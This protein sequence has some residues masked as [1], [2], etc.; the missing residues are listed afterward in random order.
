MYQETIALTILMLIRMVS[1]QLGRR[2]VVRDKVNGQFAS[3]F[4][5]CKFPTKSWSFEFY[6]K[7]S[8]Q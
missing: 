7:E 3:Q 8:S 2:V 1:S 6:T 4:L 5:A